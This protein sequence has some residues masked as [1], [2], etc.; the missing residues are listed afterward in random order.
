MATGLFIQN[1][2]LTRRLLDIAHRRN[3][4]V[5]EL[6]LEWIERETDSPENSLLIMAKA[7]REA[8]LVFSENDVA[9]RSRE[10]LSTDFA[11]ELRQRMEDDL[12]E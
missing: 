4:T 6:L 5:E 9:E 12:G 7:A 2:H 8:N 11:D 1:E 10:I 3:R